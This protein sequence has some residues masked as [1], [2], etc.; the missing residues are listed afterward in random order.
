[1]SDDFFRFPHTPHI[2]WL[3][4]AVARDDKVLPPGEIA[5]LLSGP[6]KVEEKIDGANLGFSVGPDGQLRAQNRGQYLAEPYTGQFQRLSEWIALHSVG[7][8]NALD[9]SL[10]AFGEWCAAR[11]SL[12]YPALPDW[13]LLFD[14]YDRRKGRFWSTRRRDELASVLGL[15]TVPGIVTGPQTVA[16]LIDGVVHWKSRYR[17]GGLEG[18]VVRRETDDWLVTRGKLVRADF[19][20]SIDSHWRSRKLEW[21]RVQRTR[22]RSD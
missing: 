11:H 17:N 1:M 16:A 13:W 12:D 7:L 8:V 2:V 18:V 10:I 14:V 5:A 3:G 4:D 9:D 19:T 22:L 21:N 15:A 6:A 20:Q